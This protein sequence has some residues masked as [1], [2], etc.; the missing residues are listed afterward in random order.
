MSLTPEQAAKR[1]GKLC[2][3]ESPVIMGGDGTKGLAA[4]VRRKAGERVFGDLGEEGYKS[5]AM[6]R[7]S[8]VEDAALDWFELV[9]DVALL[10]Q[11]HIDHPTIPNVAATPDGLAPGL[12]TVEAKS[13]TFHVFCDTVDDWRNGKRGLQCVPSEYRW[14][15]RWQPWCAGLTQGRFVAFHPVRGGQ[16]IV[17]PYEITQSDRDAMAERVVTVE[18]LIRNWV[19]ILKGN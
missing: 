11:Q 17:V 7:G 5:W 18:A 1:L 10:R 12:F 19:E 9:N 6:D 3:S 8:E 4:L 13:P 15:C 16:G 14:Q 2:A